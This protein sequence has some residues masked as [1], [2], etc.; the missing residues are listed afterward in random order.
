M[1]LVK[2]E[3]PH[4]RRHYTVDERERCGIFECLS[5]GQSFN[6]GEAV[7]VGRVGEN[8]T[9][10]ILLA[11]TLVVIVGNVL[12]WIRLLES[13]P[14]AAEV[15]AVEV[16]PS[17][18]P[19]DFTA[20]ADRVAALEKSVAELRAEWKKNAAE[21]KSAAETKPAAAGENSDVI[22]SIFFRLGR[23]ESDIARLKGD[24]RSVPDGL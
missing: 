22:R 24:K 13:V 18:A 16:V 5:C 7:V 14:V 10:R 11:L 2:L 21:T 1:A 23:L 17:V 12:L 19:A 4:C 8:R 6:G 3:C 9:M 20:L 15:N